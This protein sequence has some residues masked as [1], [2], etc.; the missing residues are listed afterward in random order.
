MVYFLAFSSIQGR[1][2]VIVAHRLST[3]RNADSI[4]VI[5]EGVIIE[6]G[7]HNELVAKSDGAYTRLISLQQHSQI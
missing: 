1:T 3:I 4:A 7:T 6:E 2:S 5:Q